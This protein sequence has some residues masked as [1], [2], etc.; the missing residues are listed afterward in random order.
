V[1]PV[2]ELE[3]YP[4]RTSRLRYVVYG[5]IVVALLGGIV[6]GIVAPA[7]D[8][9]VKPDAAPEFSLASLSGET[10]TSR[11]LRGH[12]VVLNFWA[13]WCPPCREEAPLL[14]A[15]WR[16]YEEQGV[17]F[18]GVNIRDHEADARRFVERYGLTF[19]ILRDPDQILADE[20]GVGLGLPQTFFI[21]DDWRLLATV[22]GDELSTLG[23][24][25][26]L[27]AISE[28]ELDRNIRAL[29]ET[30]DQ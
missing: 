25:Q 20:L 13:S 18:V 17:R 4:K 28:E 10:L 14:E 26:I 22:S 19:P 9:S 11:Q 29:L 23:G 16:E 27:G 2:D 30:S 1:I 12:P 6:Y 5:L 21:T 15:K 8:E 7:S 24:T 3:G